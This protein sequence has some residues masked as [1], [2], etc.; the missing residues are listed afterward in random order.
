MEGVGHY[1]PLRHYAEVHLVLEPGAPGQRRGDCHQLPGG[2]AGGQLAAADPDPPGGE[3]PPGP[4]DWA[5]LSL[6]CK[7]TLAA[8]RAHIK[9]TEGGDF[10]Q[11]TYRAVRQGL[12]TAQ[13]QGACVL[14]EPWYQFTLRVPQEPRGPG[15]GGH[16]P[17]VCGV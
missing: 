16:A 4:A 8:G 1:E 14:L 9:H 2:R 3:D 6:T 12:R 13:A 15:S 11:A 17:A 7:I 10:R 5:R